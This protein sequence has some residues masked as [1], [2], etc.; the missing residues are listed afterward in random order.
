[1]EKYNN[2]KKVY[3]HCQQRVMV[4]VVGL[5]V[6]QN[7]VDHDNFDVFLLF[8]PPTKAHTD[9]YSFVFD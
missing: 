5:I 2:N 4:M 6:R 3:L 8:V 7:S 1:M 9:K